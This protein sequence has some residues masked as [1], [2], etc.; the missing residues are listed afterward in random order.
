MKGVLRQ[1]RA[2]ACA[3]MQEHNSN[4]IVRGGHIKIFGLRRKLKHAGISFAKLISFFDYC[5]LKKSNNN[6]GQ[7]KNSTFTRFGFEHCKIQRECIWKVFLHY[8]KEKGPGGR[9]SGIPAFA[10]ADGSHT[11]NS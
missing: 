5:C 7:S 10:P 9:R 2:C 11:G 4:R 3:I 8:K 1:I 6:Q